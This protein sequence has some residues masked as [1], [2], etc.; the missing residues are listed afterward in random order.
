MWD[1]K[2]GE[3]SERLQVEIEVRGQETQERQIYYNTLWSKVHL[4]R[5]MHMKHTRDLS[6]GN[7]GLTRTEMLKD[8]I[9]SLP[10]PNS[11]NCRVLEGLFL[12]WSGAED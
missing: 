1:M 11:F 10:I 7:W 4:K 9:P 8:I 6:Q 12:L 5:E 3:I 2:K